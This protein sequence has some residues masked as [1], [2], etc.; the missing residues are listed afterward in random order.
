MLVGVPNKDDAFKTHPMNILNERTLKGTF[1]GNYKPRTD[2]PGVVEKYMNKVSW[3]SLT[4][5]GLFPSCDSSLPGGQC[6]TEFVHWATLLRRSWNWKSSSPTQFLFRIS[7]RHSSTCCTDRAFDA[8]SAWRNKHPALEH[9]K[10]RAGDFV[11]F[12]VLSFH[13]NK[14]FEQD[15]PSSA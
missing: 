14:S 9:E 12:I 6:V 11:G 4:G 7:T 8:S 13:T 3:A 15:G 2:I 5:D 1:F 10:R